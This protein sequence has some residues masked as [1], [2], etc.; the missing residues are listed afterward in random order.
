MAEFDSSSFDAAAVEA[1]KDLRERMERDPKLA[2][3][4][5]ELA[6]WWGK[7]FSSAGHKRLGRIIKSL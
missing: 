3:A 1:E 6:S 2:A 5:K 4:L 7:W